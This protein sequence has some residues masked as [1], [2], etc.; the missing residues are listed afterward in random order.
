[1]I[2]LTGAARS[3]LT[4]THSTSSQTASCRRREDAAAKPF[5]SDVAI[6]AAASVAAARKARVNRVASISMNLAL[7]LST[8]I[9]LREA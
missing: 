8:A 7:R 1:M 6:T 9:R 4:V 2:P 5:A 3:C